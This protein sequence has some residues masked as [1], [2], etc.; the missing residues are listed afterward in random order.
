MIPR[1]TMGIARESDGVTRRWA[2]AVGPADSPLPGTDELFEAVLW[3]YGTRR[4]TALDPAVVPASRRAMGR[5]A[6]P[7]WC[8]TP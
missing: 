2:T 5:S 4:T 3:Q 8:A 6:M 7:T 1:F